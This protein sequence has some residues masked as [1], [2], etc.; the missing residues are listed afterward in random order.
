MEPIEKEHSRSLSFFQ[1]IVTVILGAGMSYW[2]FRLGLRR[3]LD[4][5]DD[6]HKTDTLDVEKAR[7]RA[8]SL[9]IRAFVR[10]SALALCASFFTGL[11]F[12]YVV[13][14]NHRGIPKRIEEIEMDTL[15]REMGY[16]GKKPES[17]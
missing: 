12:S 7:I 2:G 13:E 1:G 15:Y 3:Q 9:A 10:G 5:T 17:E 6:V 16:D 4:K 14:A 11:G 8:K